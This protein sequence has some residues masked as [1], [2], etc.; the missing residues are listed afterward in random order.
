M[1]IA[2]AGAAGRMGQ[3]LIAEI[4]RTDGCSLAAAL[5]GAGSNK[6]G[7]DAGGGVKIVSD[8]AAAIGAAEAVIDFEVTPNR[9]DWLGVAGIARDLAAAGVG[10]LKERPIEPVAGLYPCPVEIRIAAPEACPAST[11][12]AIPS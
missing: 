9:P 11:I 4:A 3:M 7:T 8:A 2:I 5:E 12:F 10:T 1:K 6:L